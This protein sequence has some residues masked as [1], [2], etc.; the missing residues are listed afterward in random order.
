MP[1]PTYLDTE[2][3]N[4]Y[5]LTTDNSTY[6]LKITNWNK[7]SLEI[8]IVNLITNFKYRELY[9]NM[10]DDSPIT[11]LCGKMRKNLNIEVV[12]HDDRIVLKFPY[13][14]TYGFGFK[15]GVGKYIPPSLIF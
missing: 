10:S 4:R 11:T 12:E 5:T 9:L 8:E 2:T 7:Y 6:R 3:I 15:L 13:D 1:I 14:P